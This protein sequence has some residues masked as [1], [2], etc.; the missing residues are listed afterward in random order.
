MLNDFLYLWCN[1]EQPKSLARWFKVWL[2]RFFHLYGVC[3]LL[4][5]PALCRCFGAKIGYLAVL[6]KCRFS[7]HPAKLTVGH[8]T[9]LGRCEIALHDRVT[10]GSR[11]VI[12]DGAV[13]LTASHSITDPQWGLK[14]APIV[15]GDYAWIATN[16]ILLPGVTVGKGAVVG[17]G[18][19][20]RSDVAD[21][22][23]VIGNPAITQPRQRTSE[24]SYCPVMLNAPFEAWVGPDFGSVRQEEMA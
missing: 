19:V 11:V 12:N 17:A 7:G 20:V 6:G 10:I 15:I 5:R 16:A 13:L 8:E 9:T 24:L 22:A 18:A 1:R 14:K 23:V 21:Y 4:F 3:R 2:K